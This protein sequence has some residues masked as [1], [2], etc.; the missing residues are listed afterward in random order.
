MLLAELE[1]YHSRTNAP[2]R[3]VALGY[4]YLPLKNGTGQGAVL[5]S[6]IIARFMPEID[7]D[8]HDDYKKLLYQLHQSAKQIGGENLAEER[9]KPRI[10][11]R[12]FAH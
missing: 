10:R 11:L 2:T 5:L 7:Q 9:L 6:G 1:I 12:L 4:T 8:F 3:R